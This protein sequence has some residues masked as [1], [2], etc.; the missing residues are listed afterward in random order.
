MLPK[1]DPRNY[2]VVFS[3]FGYKLIV[4]VL[5]G[6]IGLGTL[7]GCGSSIKNQIVVYNGQHLELTQALA[8]GFERESGIKV[9]LESNSSVVLAD[10]VISEGKR[11]PADVVFFENS[12]EL[13]VLEQKGLLAK[14]PS[15]TLVQV[16]PQYSSPSSEWV[17]VALRVNCLVYNPKKISA[18]Q[19]PTSIL[20]L[21]NP[22]W[23]GKIAIAPSDPDFLPLVGAVAK[24]YRAPEA[25]AWLEGLKKN[26]AIFQSDEAVTVAVNNGSYSVGIVNQ[27][28]W[29]RLEKEV[30]SK[31][32]ASKIY[33]FPAGNIGSLENVS[34]I[35]V[36]KGSSNYKEAVKFIDYV[37]SRTGQEVISGD[38]D[39]EY[40]ARVGVE[41]NKSLTPLDRVHPFTMS[42][43]TLGTDQLASNL[44]QQIGLL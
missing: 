22:M 21:A 29:Y 37:V 16:P 30:G 10:Q 32:M 25:K 38:D 1:K 12:P 28:Y 33:Y 42:V 18:S 4:M 43:V 2:L 20:Q 36:L 14:L 5:V 17:G 41:P 11:S 35:A 39:F 6:F 15:S 31:N 19:L 44:L 24:E 27:Y 7:A 13:M 23:K 9:K 26:A 3:Q 8:S 34:G 40:P